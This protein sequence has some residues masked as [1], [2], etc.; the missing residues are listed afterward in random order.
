MLKF[1]VL[2]SFT[3]LFYCVISIAEAKD[4]D[5]EF[6][7][8][9]DPVILEELSKDITYAETFD[10][11]KFKD[12]GGELREGINGKGLHVEKPFRVMTEKLNFSTGTISWWLQL[13]K[14]AI[15]RIKFLWGPGIYIDYTGLKGSSDY[16]HVHCKGHYWNKTNGGV[17]GINYPNGV[18]PTPKH[19]NKKWTHI[20]LT[21][22]GNKSEVYV[23]GTRRAWMNAPKL[24]SDL[25]KIVK[26]LEFGDKYGKP[27]QGMVIDEIR[28]YNRAL[29][30]AEIRNYFRAAQSPAL[31][32][33]AFKIP[34]KLATKN[35][36]AIDSFYRLSDSA[37]V[38]RADFSEFS[39]LSLLGDI[40]GKI[41]VKN[42]QGKL[43]YESTFKVKK[44]E[45][46][47]IHA[48]KLKD[49]LPEGQ[50]NVQVGI[51]KKKFNTKLTRKEW[52][53]E[54]N[55]IGVVTKV[56]KPW[57][58][59]KVTSEGML[60][61]SKP[62][63][64]VW[65]RDYTL[66]GMG[67]PASIKTLQ[68]EPTRKIKIADILNGSVKLIAIK[69]G[70]ELEWSNESFK[71][72][73][74]NDIEAKITGS[75]RNDSLKADLKGTLEFDG[76]YKIN[77]Q[78]K[79]LIDNLS[80]DKLFLKI[81]VPSKQAKLF[82][83]ASDRMRS[84]KAFLDLEKQKNGIIWDSI[85]SITRN[86][87]QKLSKPDRRKIPVWPQVWIGNDDRGIALSLENAKTWLIDKKEPTMKLIKGEK[88]TYLEVLLINT[89][90]TLKKT[91]ETTFALQ[92]TPV[93]PRKAGGS[94][95]NE[96]AYGWNY[97]DA[98]IIKAE[99]FDKNNKKNVRYSSPEAKAED[100]WWRYGCMQS[101][102][103]P[104]EDPVYGEMV[105][106]N[107]NEWGV[108]VYTPSH[109]DFLLWVYKKWHD[110]KGMDGFYFDNTYPQS[111]ATVENR[112]A[113]I[114]ENGETQY[115]YNVFNQR[116][117]AKRT[118]NYFQSVGP[119]PV[120]HT[121]VTDCPFVAYLGFFDIWMD[122]ENGGFPPKQKKKDPFLGSKKFDFV[123]RWYTPTG[124]T[125]LRIT[126]GRQWGSMPCYLYAWGIEPTYAILGLFDLEKG[127]RSM[128][129]K[130]Y[131]DFGR[132]EEDV[133]FI[134]YWSP[135][136][137]AIKVNKKDF[138]VSAWKRPGQVRLLICNLSPENSKVDL[139]I[140]LKELG[141]NSNAIA[142]DE[143][144]G[145][146]IK[147]E[148]GIIK[149]LPVYRHDYET[150][151]IANPEI[152]QPL[153]ADLGKKLNP[154][155]EKWLP[156]LCDDFKTL[157]EK[158]WQKYISPNIDKA[159]SGAKANNLFPLCIRKGYLRFRTGTSICDSISM[160]FKQDNCSVQVKM[161]EPFCSPHYVKTYHGPF[162]SK[163]ELEWSDGSTAGIRAW[164]RLP[165][166]KEKLV[167]YGRNDKGKDI[168]KK[169]EG[170]WARTLWVKLVLTPEKIEYYSSTDGEKW[171]LLTTFDRKKYFIGAP[172]LIRLG[173][174]N[175]KDSYQESHVCDSYFD[176]LITAKL[177]A[178]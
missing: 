63:I 171:N 40:P 116:E 99:Y 9:I 7:D 128:G 142:L 34:E 91:I 172:D 83:A 138:L 60:L 152:H 30:E 57:T 24:F 43:I 11:E 81:A 150:L 71:I 61:W 59:L 64:K 3:T 4:S 31:K 53:W 87:T 73:E 97:F 23:N 123:D 27:Y 145:S 96:K 78:I 94:W 174:G 120:L 38:L 28:F 56:P 149:D 5:A 113:W 62:V 33:M 76:F 141:L 169:L 170:T 110:E 177:K 42:K 139:K 178:E 52:E 134:P 119:L 47:F 127:Y 98:P 157:D 93:R 18:P 8:V 126:L 109:I 1:A 54:K 74:S 36:L 125:N 85:N 129:R 89:P 154:S 124:M 70:K 151:I 153:S 162:G 168:F 21:W 103:V 133:R 173:H 122:G 144:E 75:A 130:P 146:Q 67:L 148:N 49:N 46:L 90:S 25:K 41:S 55:K 92:A 26:Y 161:I 17:A 15:K 136:S 45:K 156:E 100:R 58:P 102:R 137:K 167:C 65:G 35:R 159:T 104:E 69:D 77:L 14:E 143:R 160:P 80:L 166:G 48:F 13:D 112:L 175:D 163:L 176:D 72:T 82:N 2:L 84:Q 165:N 22:N 6:G 39:Y 155:K 147:M 20:A 121:H 19:P 16:R 79:P 88:E 105:L 37:I 114:D 12:K 50:Y 107:R 158:K 66:S 10:D 86:A 117:F 115:G 108:G 95:K 68:P 111:Q 135:D 164:E 140:D 106:L 44:P 118:Q 29:S 32:K 51:A 131:H 132:F 101:H